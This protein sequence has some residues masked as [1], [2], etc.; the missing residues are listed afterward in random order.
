GIFARGNWMEEWIVQKLKEG[1][2]PGED[3]YFLGDEQVSFYSN[4]I[5]VSG[6]PDGLYVN[7]NTM[8]YRW[9]EFK[10]TQN[11]ITAPKAAHKRQILTNMGLVEHLKETDDRLDE[12]LDIPL[13]S[14]ELEGG[15]LV[16]V[17]S[18]NYL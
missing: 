11:P 3:F 17:D 14:M 13:S 5:K 7:Y 8:T 2:E 4:A 10:S 15:N 18:S 1:V 12:F 6:T 16:Y 9:L